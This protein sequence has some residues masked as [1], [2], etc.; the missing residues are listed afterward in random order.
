MFDIFYLVLLG[1]PRIFASHLLETPYE[2]FV[3][4]GIAIY[5]NKPPKRP[6]DV[7]VATID[8]I[9]MYNRGIL[10]PKGLES[11]ANENRPPASRLARS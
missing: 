6:P 8:R 5:R 2:F 1:A 3:I 10:P 9:G 7:H 4:Y 11:P